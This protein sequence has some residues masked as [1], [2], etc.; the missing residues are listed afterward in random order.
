MHLKSA[1]PVYSRVRCKIIKEGCHAYTLDS[2]RLT[3]ADSS[4]GRFDNHLPISPICQLLAVTFLLSAL[5]VSL[6]LRFLTIILQGRYYYYLHF[7]DRETEAGTASWTYQPWQQ[8]FEHFAS[9]ANMNQ[10][11]KQFNTQG[12]SLYPWVSRFHLQI[13]SSLLPHP[14]SP[15]PLYVE[16]GLWIHFTSNKC[17]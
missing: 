12:H 1:L 3:L 16:H 6:S 9:A 2:G 13:V 11:D 7:T 17:I 5:W 10:F 15:N 14:P 8:R 4:F